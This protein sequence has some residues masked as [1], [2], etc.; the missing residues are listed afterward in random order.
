M[1]IVL[2]IGHTL[3]T[4]G[5]I[6][7]MA[8]HMLLLTASP[9]SDEAYLELRNLI[10]LISNY[11]LLPSLGVALFTGLFAMVVHRPFQERRW[12]WLKAA[13]GILMFKGVLTIVGESEH[14][15]GIALKIVEGTATADALSNPYNELGT[16]WVV[17]LLSIVNV[18]LG[19]WRPRLKRR[20]A[21]AQ[22]A[23]ARAA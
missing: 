10:V 16:L 1:R 23:P 13:L 5:L 17:M 2:K 6:G 22:P 9:A 18:V 19:V 12:A 11:V 4:C 7:G 20:P 3:A 21:P 15:A 8:V 14:A